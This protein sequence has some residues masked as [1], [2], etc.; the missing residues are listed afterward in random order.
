MEE[1]KEQDD[2]KEEERPEGPSPILKGFYYGEERD[3]WLSMV[4]STS[5]PTKV[6]TY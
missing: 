5:A 4:N 1:V 2:T 3:F 6:L